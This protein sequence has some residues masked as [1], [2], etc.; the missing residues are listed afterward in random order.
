MSTPGSSIRGLSVYPIDMR[1]REPF[2]ISGGAQPLAQAAIV[3]LELE[4]GTVGTGEAAPL[5]AYNGETREVALAA[6]ERA[7]AFVE[8]GD[9]LAWR[10]IAA[11][12]RSVIP[13]SG[14]ARCAIE[15][16]ILDALTRRAGMS[17]RA[18]FGGAQLSLRTDVTLPIGTAARAAEAAGAWQ[19]RGFDTLKIKVGGQ[20]LR[21]DVERVSAVCGAA[22]GARILLDANGAFSAEESLELLAELRARGITIDLFEQPVAKDD[23]A[24]F[25]RVADSGVVVAADESVV[26]A[27]DAL[28]AAVRLGPPHAINVKLMKAG[29]LEALDV[30]ATARAAGMRT[31]VGGML[32]SSLA[33]S[34]S[35][36]FAAGL[37]GFAFADLDTHLFLVDAPFHGGFEVR[38]SLLDL[39][40]IEA[41]HGVRWSGE[42]TSA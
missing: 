9:A 35:A 39:T 19:A 34:A 7:R 40:R 24:G 13:E 21:E 10:R 29:V 37:G 26:T 33:M 5:P 8:G 2:V 27:A 1:L 6:I 42:A 18:F 14:A 11:D 22:P 15:T 4:D 32:E 31:M 3:I 20:H 41:G 16:A 25:R 12:L 17:L 30:T 23:W 36:C 28:R 38:G